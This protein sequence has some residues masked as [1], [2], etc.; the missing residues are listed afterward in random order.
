M[1][2]HE[3][4]T[5]SQTLVPARR[6]GD[7]HQLV[8]MVGPYASPS[9]VSKSPEVVSGSVDPSGMWHGFRRRWLLA[10]MLG[11][12]LA[13]LAA[14]GLYI[15]FPMSNTAL[16]F[17]QVQSNQPTI[18]GQGDPNEADFKTFR[19]TQLAYLRS[20]R[21]LSAALNDPKLRGTPIDFLDREGD[22]KIKFLQDNLIARFDGDS[23]LLQLGLSL[24]EPE[25]DLK[26]V[27]NAVANAY[28]D[29]VVN[30]QRIQRSGIRDALN[31]N[32]LELNEEI[33]NLYEQIAQLKKDLNLTESGGVD[34]ET[35]LIL[36]D[37]SMKMQDRQ[38]AEDRLLSVTL[39]YQMYLQQLG[40]PTIQ[41]AKLD[42]QLASDPNVQQ[43]QAEITQIQYYQRQASNTSKRGNSPTV[44]RYNE[45]LQRLQQELAQYKAEA[46]AQMANAGS[47]RPDPER[48]MM[49]M[50]FRTAASVYQ[51]QIKQIDEE[52]TALKEQLA[53]KADKSTDLYVLEAEVEQKQAIA[54]DIA[55]KVDNWDIELTADA[56]IQQI[57][58]E[59]F[60]IP[61]IS[62]IQQYAIAGVGGLATFSLVCLGIAYL[63]FLNR[64]LN[65][66]QQIDEGLGIRVLG[67]LPGLG[68][69][70]SLNPRHPLVAQLTESVDSVRTALM[71][72]ATNKQRQVI[73]VTSPATKEGRTTVASQLAVSLAR[74]G[75]RTLLI[76]ADIRS[77]SLHRMFDLPLEDGL[78]EVL[79]AESDVGDVIQPS[80]ADGLWLLTAGYCDA[81]AVHAMATDQIQPI[82]EK[83]RADYDFIIIDGAPVLGLSDSLMMGQHCDGAILSVLRDQTSVPKIYQS[84]ELLRSVGI[85]L[86][87]SVV[88]GVKSKADKRITRLRAATPKAER[89]Q[90]E[91]AK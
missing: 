5:Q 68:G 71:H 20:Q 44:N 32:Y 4:E 54:R 1:A 80:Q 25:E 29:N 63:E 47:G 15:A 59:A 19:A 31:K 72:E 77:P 23:E 11:L 64:K 83:L 73:L 21:V 37:L 45:Q 13:S 46:K 69:R 26:I 8:A 35:K 70:K 9:G 87:G 17:F 78:C 42:A 10:T 24:N 86:I 40:N 58:R 90:L 6:V 34:N 84:A 53:A 16:M 76:D 39:Q 56:R 18:I 65:G 48:A 62:S 55:A 88:N 2:T 36:S 75:R 66:P 28:I 67:I 22:N 60:V 33:R 49:D 81:D 79:R 27:V 52:I 82:F 7:D 38:K 85:R 50:Q 43:I 3:H 30:T 14:V 41:D 74:A 51:N 91:A 61:G 12:F 89:K 57:D